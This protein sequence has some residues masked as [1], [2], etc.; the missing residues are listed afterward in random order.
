MTDNRVLESSTNFPLFRIPFLEAVG[1][2][3]LPRALPG[4]CRTATPLDAATQ[5]PEG[6]R[7]RNWNVKTGNS[8]GK[9]LGLFP[10]AM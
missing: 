7:A 10:S 9:M 8:G 5:L 6:S 4:A 3:L 1:Q 2:R